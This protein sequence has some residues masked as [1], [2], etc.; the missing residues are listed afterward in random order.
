MP[1]PSWQTRNLKTYRL[2]DRELSGAGKPFLQ[3]RKT[4]FVH[5]DPPSWSP[6]LPRQKVMKSTL[7]FLLPHILRGERNDIYQLLLTR[8]S[9]TPWHTM[10]EMQYLSTIFLSAAHALKPGSDLQT[11]WAKVWNNPICPKTALHS[12]WVLGRTSRNPAGFRW[13]LYKGWC[14]LFLFLPIVGSITRLKGISL[15]LCTAIQ[16]VS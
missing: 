5:W 2:R 12:V 6:E 3:H 14:V 15:F 4:P 11:F 8:A 1:Y 10:Q 7:S 13:S 16:K 9:V